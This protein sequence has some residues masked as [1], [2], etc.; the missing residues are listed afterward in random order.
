MELRQAVAWVTGASRGLGRALVEALLERGARVAGMARSES[1]LEEL[2]Q[3]SSGRFLPLVGDV[4]RPADVERAVR[5]I[6]NRWGTVHVLV[7]NAGLG[8]FANVEELSIEDWQMQIETNLTGVFLCTRA[9]VPLMKAQRY[10]HIVNIAS[11]AGLMGNPQLTA[12]NASKFGVRGF[13]EALMKELREFGIKVTCVY[14]GSID[15]PFFDPLGL[16]RHKNMM[17]PEEVARCIVF[18]LETSDNFLVSEIV[19]RPL[20]PNPPAS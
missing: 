7:N 12:Y 6:Q 3:R 18:I 17:Q 19:L 5:E 20:N 11:I 16:P 8:R 2:A 9:V 15:T 13:S 10:G 1:E 14:P 4:R